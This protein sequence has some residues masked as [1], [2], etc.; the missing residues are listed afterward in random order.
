MQ[1]S[2]STK[3]PLAAV[4]VVGILALL[5]L[6]LFIRIRSGSEWMRVSLDASHG[7]IFAVVAV[8]VAAL[9]ADAEGQRARAPGPTGRC[10]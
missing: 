5:S 1:T 9:L 8:L 10:I 6:L 3:V 4:L 7:P 2:N